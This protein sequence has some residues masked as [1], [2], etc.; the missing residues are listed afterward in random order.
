[1]DP[2]ALEILVKMGGLRGAR[3]V[4][5]IATFTRYGLDV[6]A[7]ALDQLERRGSVE[8]VAAWLP[9]AATHDRLVKRPDSFSHRQRIAVTVL[10]RCGARTGD[11]IAW[12]AGESA[13]DMHRVVT[14]LHRFRC[15]YHVTAYQPVGR[16]RKPP[17]EPTNRIED[18]PPLESENTTPTWG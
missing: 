8:R 16:S 6:T 10:H 9:T 13:T 5:D 17:N 18:H 4:E 11:E 15:L 14:W 3:T 12:L 7:A 1:M 2:R